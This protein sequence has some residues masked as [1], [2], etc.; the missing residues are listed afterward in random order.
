M[1]VS[2]A[3]LLSQ[4][5][6][7]LGTPDV[8]ASGLI[9]AAAP[10]LIFGL[11]LFSRGFVL[12]D[13]DTWSHIA[14]GEWILAHAQVPRS[15]PFSHSMGGAP[16]IAHE[17]LAEVLFALAFRWSGLS[18]VALLAAVAGAG[19]ILVMAL[20]VARDLSGPALLAVLALAVGL[21]LDSLLARPH[22]LA[23]P[24]M[25]AWFSCLLAA[26]DAGGAPP[27]WLAGL[28]TPWSNMHGGFVFGLALIVPFAGE[29]V[30][31]AQPGDRFR[32]ARRWALFGFSA[33]A[34]ALVNPYGID[35]LLL[36]LRL[37]SLDNLSQISEWAPQD[38]SRIN[39]M[40]ITLVTL[41]GFALA[42]PMATPLMRS[43]LVAILIALALSHVRYMQL[44]GIIGPMALAPSVAVAIARPKPSDENRALTAK[45]AISAALAVG[46]GLALLRMTSPIV[47]SDGL[48]VPISAL[49]AVPPELRSKPVLNDYAFGGYLIWFGVRPFI[50]ARA[51]MYGNSMF[52][53]YLEL[54]EGDPDT[55]EE[56]LRRYRIAWTIFAPSDRIVSVLDRKPGWRRIYTDQFAVV[57]VRE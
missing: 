41:V 5:R 10:L 47:Q 9:V 46:L 6:K 22:L 44:L 27:I 52:N 36:P 48:G 24:L 37:A 18:G 51:D 17:W 30:F 4:L 19:A 23:L 39:W 34:A 26:R 8:L 21:C 16:W 15:D 49:R 29:A 55:I 56:T 43:A 42:R 50:D 25:A 57:H 54:N 28:M 11:A 33:T 40:E 35:L 13:G 14:T 7:G 38:F 1:S 31:E 2:G 32:L 3:L 53:L 12:N 20:R 45:L